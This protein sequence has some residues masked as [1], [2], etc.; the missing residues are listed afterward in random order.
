MTTCVTGSLLQDSSVARVL[1]GAAMAGSG[2]VAY[3]GVEARR[4]PHVTPHRFT[5]A[6]GQIWIVVPDRALKVRALRKRPRAGVLVR[7]RGGRGVVVT[8]IAE[9]HSLR[10]PDEAAR[11]AFHLPSIAVAGASFAAR[12]V[13]Q[14]AGY[15][16]DLLALTRGSMPLDRVLIAIRPDSATVLD[17]PRAS[18]VGGLEECWSGIA[19]CLPADVAP[20]LGTAGDA[21]LGLS[22]PNG[23]LPLPA[24]WDPSGARIRV[25]A[26]ALET[27]GL[28]SEAPASLTLDHSAGGRPSGFRG[29][30]VQGSGTVR[31]DTVTLTPRAA[32]WWQ[33][34]KTGSG[35]HRPASPGRPARGC[36][37]VAAS[38]HRRRDGT[39]SGAIGSGGAATFAFWRT[40]REA[41]GYVTSRTRFAE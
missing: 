33:G 27:F 35:P 13:T 34:F 6:A 20:L 14:M 21:V 30:V 4:G 3:L 38:D 29:V 28:P 10:T 37:R 8:G 24:R 2:G 16:L 40:L 36:R 9:I 26:A 1:R 25:P 17:A 31:G 18:D 39:L 15:A 12:N 19:E 22:T 7:G 5:A 11:A 41:V 23:P 32:S